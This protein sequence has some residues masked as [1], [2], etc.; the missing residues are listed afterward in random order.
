MLLSS[1]LFLCHTRVAQISPLVWESEVPCHLC[2][3]RILT[4]TPRFVVELSRDSQP[5]SG[6]CVSL[7]STRVASCGYAPPQHVGCCHSMAL[8]H[9]SEAEIVS[10]I[11]SLRG[12][13]E[14]E[15]PLRNFQRILLPLWE[16]PRGLQMVCH[17]IINCS[18]N[19]RFKV[20]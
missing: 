16:V 10:G 14:G 19:D 1:Y 5:L 9:G 13:H 20:S 12:S 6:Q 4:H 2:G 18:L 8:E 11:G 15:C 7:M 17:V 3:C